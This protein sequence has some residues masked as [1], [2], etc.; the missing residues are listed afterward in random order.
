MNFLPGLVGATLQKDACAEIQRWHDIGWHKIWPP[1][2]AKETVGRSQWEAYL[3]AHLCSSMVDVAAKWRPV[4]HAHNPSLRLSVSSVFTHQTPMVVWPPSGYARLGRCELADLLVCFIDRTRIP[5]AGSAILIQAKQSDTTSVKLSAPNE[6]KQFELLSVRPPFR[7]DR[8][9][10]L[11]P[12]SVDLGPI[13][14]DTALMYGLNEPDSNPPSG[15]FRAC[16]WQTADGLGSVKGV[17]AVTSTTCMAQTLVDLVHGRVGWDFELPPNGA[18][19]SHFTA[20]AYKDDWSTLVNYLLEDTFLRRTKYVSLV[21][22]NARGFRGND[23][24][25]CIV[26]MDG[27]EKFYHVFAGVDDAITGPAPLDWLAHT[28]THAHTV[29]YWDGPRSAEFWP[30]PSNRSTRADGEPEDGPI[31][32]IVF[33]VSEGESNAFERT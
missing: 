25:M 22:A 19:W 29:A 8:K 11:A 31:S 33:E 17:Y 28:E 16:R 32:A 12:Q 6:R 10:G 21:G 15:H 14:S 26:H 20:P 13:A 18:N 2:A 23:Q 9:V 27:D 24:M 1:G 30:P 4:V 7:I 5:Q 3:A